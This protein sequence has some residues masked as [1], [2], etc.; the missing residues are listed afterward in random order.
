MNEVLSRSGTGDAGSAIDPDEIVRTAESLYGLLDKYAASSDEQGVLHD[1]V[2]SALHDVGAVKMFLPRELGGLEL[3]P[4][5]AMRLIRALSYADPSAGWAGMALATATGL[6]G[7]FFPADTARELFAE[8]S[9]TAIAGQGTKPG[10]AVPVDGGHLVSG[11][12]SFASGIKHATHVHTAAIDA[13]TGQSRFFVLPIAE[14]T[15][16]DNWEVLGLRATGSLD[17]VLDEV[18]VPIGY[19]YPSLSRE[20]VTG[21]DLYRLG[22]GNL[23]SINHGSWALGVGRRML[24]ELA[25][26]VRSTG[27]GL[28]D[29]FHGEYAT[30]EATLRSAE[31]LL[32]DAWRDIERTQDRGDHP[33]VRQ[34]TLNRLALNNATWS[35][36]AVAEF[37]YRSAGTIALRSGVIQRLFRDVHAGTQHISSSATIRQ[38][39]GRELAGLAEKERWVHFRL[40]RE[41]G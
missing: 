10:R 26:F 5:D 3:R 6:A 4:T 39:C 14:A 12:W 31:A 29:A 8:G 19:S 34:E 20:P 25:A 23:A 36:Q 32:F 37:A 13:V 35:M 18:F 17:Y 21:G 22:I 1:A 7:A 15:I 30:A 16:I 38:S 40:V 41:D 24:D 2:V 28:G 11:E 27:R 33:S 9:R